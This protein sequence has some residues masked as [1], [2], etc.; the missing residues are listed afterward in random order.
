M[1]NVYKQCS[2]GKLTF[3]PASGNGITNGV[4]EITLNIPV[5]GVSPWALENTVT[6]AATAKFGALSQF[7]HGTKKELDSDYHAFVILSATRRLTPPTVAF[8]FP[9]G[10][11]YPGV[12]TDWAAYGFIGEY[13]TFYN[14]LWCSYV[15]AQVHEVGH[16]LNLDHS[17]EDGDYGD[18][19]AIMGF[20]YPYDDFPTMCFNGAK[21][22]VLGWYDDRKIE[23]DAS[24]GWAGNIIAFV[25]APSATGND[26]VIIK[27][28]NYYIQYNRAK[29]I[30]SGTQEK[31]DELTVT[32][33]NNLKSTSESITGLSATNKIFIFQHAK[34]P[35]RVEFCQALKDASGVDRVQV[36]V[37]L[38]SVGSGCN[39]ATLEQRSVPITPPPT[40]APTLRP[41]AKP[42]IALPT[43]N[44]VNS[45][46][47]KT[48]GFCFSG[49]TTVQVKEKGTIMMK[50]L[51]IGDEVLVA[52]GK[53]EP[54]YSFGHRHESMEADFLQFLPSGL[55]LS[56]D[57][58]VR[59]GGR[60]IPASM[61]KVGDD[62]VSTDGNVVS[63]EA[64][65]RVTR[66]GVYAPFTMSGTIVVSNIEASNYVAF[67]NSDRLVVGKSR[68]WE[69]P[70]S[71]QWVAHLSQSPHRI[72]WL[73]GF[74]GAAEEYSSNGMSTWIAGPHQ[75][76]EWV[77]EQNSAVMA[78][79]VLPALGVGLMSSGVEW[80]ISCFC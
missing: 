34:G 27:V 41:T 54:V 66:M 38:E 13:R 30:N 52:T 74:S 31:R 40:P 37:Y 28:D 61:V 12:G 71:F 8:C 4:G 16:N 5:T 58:M 75:L 46:A 68:G 72:S 2:H 22:W 50:N 76:A 11:S 29:G 32:Q 77:V 17:N 44:A 56:A 14:D 39:S 67:R 80:L 18:G 1:S 23:I 79:L 9:K 20:S 48:G 63:V 49:D 25:D 45:V 62:L 7:A 21:H 24:Q 70:M 59:A 35:A 3:S 47:K 43:P 53:Y 15:S 26:V 33:T 78:L 6:S 19:S 73:L 51:K 55:E 42:T 10:T 36:S 65:K 64:I 57:H 60:F 69:T